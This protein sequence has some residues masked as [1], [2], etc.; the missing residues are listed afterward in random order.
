MKKVYLLVQLLVFVIYADAQVLYST[1]QEGGDSWGTIFSYDI[2]TE[3]ASIVYNFD[4]D[5]SYEPF[6]PLLQTSDNKLYGLSQPNGTLFSFNPANGE[7]L[8]LFRHNDY[9]SSS[10]NLIEASDGNMYVTASNASGSAGALFLCDFIDSMYKSVLDFGGEKGSVP[11]KGLVEINGKLY[12]TTKLGG[13]FNKGTIFSFDL[14][15]LIY[16]KLHD[17][18]GYD[19]VGGY[20]LIVGRDG[21]LY[22]SA[23]G[24]IYERGVLFS[25]D[26]QT[27]EY[28]K[29]LDIFSTTSPSQ[30]LLQAYDGKIYGLGLTLDGTS[31][32]TIFSYD[33]SNNAFRLEQKFLSHHGD[34]GNPME[35]LMEAS[36]GMLYGILPRSGLG[37]G[38]A[39]RFDPVTKIVDTI[40]NF[41][42]FGVAV[43]SGPFTEYCSRK[44]Y[45]F[46]TD[47]DGFGDPANHISSCS[48]TP[49]TGYVINNND[50]DDTK[51]LYADNDGDGYGA[52]S[53]VA[54]GVPNNSDCDDNNRDV[55]PGAVE[56]CDNGIDDNCNG[57]ID[58]G[59][60]IP[61][62]IKVSI[63]NS[64]GYEGNRGLHYMNFKVRLNKRTK[65]SVWIT[66]HTENGTATAGS[67]YQTQIGSVV[68]RAGEKSTRIK[69]AVIGDTVPEP[70]ETFLVRLT[71]AVN[72][73]I[74]N[75][76]ATG[77][78][79]NDDGAT[80]SRST[81]HLK[82]NT[83]T[84]KALEVMPNPARNIAKI[85]L[86][87]YSG[88]V[89]VHLTSF[90]GRLLTQ[91]KIL[92]Y[93][94]TT[95]YQINVSDYASGIYLLT[96]ID[97]NGDKRSL[98]LIV[99]K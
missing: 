79:V 38:M 96:V 36:D 85:K 4:R 10:G 48:A 72:A 58:E 86:T 57:R 43:P 89:Q 40:I 59:C 80:L 68:I 73:G 54:C 28:I 82:S 90:D 21:K 37:G 8:N 5:F 19:G 94:K 78:I 20:D 99:A 27:F 70:D 17:F 63:D 25:F 12:G 14:S 60:A 11:S 97:E 64:I 24:G 74:E 81:E 2:N 61:E 53:P 34:D 18:T 42:I 29:L 31:S 1:T 87:G 35:G 13:E 69:V 15:T 46:D 77:T 71:G 45:Y 23:M 6:T 7:F 41:P 49:P 56:I 33:I 93:G 84:A 92:T 47:G 83:V 9:F 50:C 65:K 88:T 67:D 3:T 76:T 95:E 16:R 32:T 52:G 91:E 26:I 75:A 51:L 62:D 30:K 98:K 22:G 55:N 44:T 39:F 66:F